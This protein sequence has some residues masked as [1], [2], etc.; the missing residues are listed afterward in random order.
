MIGLLYETLEPL[1]KPVYRQGSFTEDE[2]YPDSFYCY[3]NPRT[4]GT[5]HYDNAERGTVWEFVVY[6]Y[7]SDA[8]SLES[9]LE[10]AIAA[11]RAA[12]FTI[13]GKGFQVESGEVS[14]EGRAVRA[15]I[16]ER[17]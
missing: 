12:G 14:H 1:G 5:T 13:G 16:T 4:D 10:A 2:K 15:R 17:S 11:L 9:G 3:W 7:T 6:Y 8:A